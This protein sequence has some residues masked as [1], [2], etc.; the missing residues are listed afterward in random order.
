METIIYTQSRHGGV[1][2][3]ITRTVA[4]HVES[5][6]AQRVKGYVKV[7]ISGDYLVCD[8]Q[9]SGIFYRFTQSQIAQLCFEGASSELIAST[10]YKD[11]RVFV[12]KKFFK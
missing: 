4:K 10:I 12:N 11:Y 1:T 5:N 7:Y 9:N 2:Y 6:L 8:I 3:C